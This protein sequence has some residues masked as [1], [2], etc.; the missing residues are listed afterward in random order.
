[1]H[2]VSDPSGIMI[3]FAR[4]M[5]I[6]A[7][8]AVLPRTLTEGLEMRLKLLVIAA[9]LMAYGT[10]VMAQGVEVHDHGKKKR[11]RGTVQVGEVS[12]AKVT[13]FAPVTGPVGTVVTITGANFLQQTKVKIGGRPV[14][15]MSFNATTLTFAIPERYYDG[16]ITVNH[17]G[18]GNEIPVGT[19]SV[20]VDPRIRDFNPRSGPVGT[21]VELNGEGFVAGDQIMF[22]GKPLQ[23]AELGPNRVVVIIPP[24]ASTDEFT[25]YRPSNKYSSESKQKF[26]VSMPAPTVSSIS[27][28]QGAPGTQVRISGTY[29]A[30]DDRVYYGPQQPANVVG[31]TDSYIDVQV[32]GNARQSNPFTIKG[33]RGNV[34][35]PVFVLVLNAAIARFA[36]EYGGA[37]TRVDVYGSNFAQGDQVYFNGKPLK[38]I[39]YDEQK[40]SVEIPIGAST[41][42]FVI[43][44]NNQAVATA[45]RPFEVLNAPTISGFTPTQ[46][47]GGTQVTISGSGFG[48]DTRVSYGAQQLRLTGRRGETQIDV[49]VPHGAQSQPFT[50]TSKGGSV[51]SATAFQVIEYSSIIAVSPD[52]GPVGTRVTISQQGY[53]GA[54]NFYLGNVSL[55]IVEKA[56]GRYV[57]QIPANAQTGRIDWET[58]GKRQTSNYTFTVIKE[59][60]F[61]PASGQPGTR[62]VISGSG[63]SANTHVR[64]GAKEQNVVART[65]T[66]IDI[67]IDGKPG[68]DYLYLVEGNETTKLNPAFS[69]MP[70]PLP[71]FV[72]PSGTKGT[73]VIISGTGFSGKTNVRYGTKEQNVVA[74]TATRIDIVIDGKPGADYLYLVEGN[75]TTKLEPAFSLTPAPLPT[76]V[77]QTGP[78]GTRVII[79][80]TGFSNNTNVRVGG[81]PQKIISRTATRIDFTLEADP[82]P[83]PIYLVEGNDTVEL[84]PAFTVIGAPKPSPPPPPPPPAGTCAFNASPDNASAG[85][86]VTIDTNYCNVK[87]VKQ[88]WFKGEPVQIVSVSPTAVVVR[89]P[90][91][92][93]GTDNIALETDDGKGVAVRV[94]TSN[95]IT[96]KAGY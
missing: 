21:R 61:V 76:F 24:G 26:E 46:G 54:D 78:V 1:M 16:V 47:P 18:S 65:A 3:T 37:G 55:P 17:P 52:K 48:P 84:Q 31:R 67:A 50:V 95:K 49:V 35:T 15:L 9:T 12:E 33:S 77:P 41:D 70:A 40:L 23:V 88:G 11:D 34:Q 63:F 28:T 14:R 57:V 20:Q 93:S 74:R 6:R 44:R 73:R 62:V 85:Q 32:P 2:D 38:R 43:W 4:L 56:P 96:V 86:T 39:S 90:A 69:L 66:R 75:E 60:T 82:G 10:P 45:N 80:G 72:P 5:N 36:P 27:P 42:R 94:R 81:K 58:Y 92:A 25:I 89:L 91:K 64:Y 30:P 19:F 83:N 68:T 22:N 7:A 87:N 29:F 51:N 59:A 13:G 53:T 79:Q 71:T 8:L